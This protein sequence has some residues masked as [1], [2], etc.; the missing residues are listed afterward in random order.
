MPIYVQR[1]LTHCLGFVFPNRDILWRLNWY[2]EVKMPL[3]TA[4][5]L[6]D[7]GS[8][9]LDTK[10]AEMLEIIEKDPTSILKQ[11]MPEDMVHS[12]KKDPLLKEESLLT[13][14]V[15]SA[16][17][18]SKA[19]MI[20]HQQIKDVSERKYEAGEGKINQLDMAEISKTQTELYETV[21]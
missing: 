18:H 16:K 11:E 8:H 7:E 9:A 1:S 4:S 15:F 12:K 21:H 19:K 3:M 20:I 6:L 13:Q 17:L 10:M 14:S 2:N 5:I